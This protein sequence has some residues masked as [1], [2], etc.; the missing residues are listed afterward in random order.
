MEITSSSS[1][2]IVTNSHN[3][4]ENVNFFV[5]YTTGGQSKKSRGF[6]F[7]WFHGQFVMV[8]STKDHQW[9]LE[10]PKDKI[11]HGEWTQIA[12][13][14]N[15]K[16]DK[17]TAFQNGNK[18]AQT[19]SSAADRPDVNF[20]IMTI[21]RPNNAVNAQFMMKMCMADLALWDKALGAKEIEKTFKLSKSL[22]VTPTQFR[23][24]IFAYSIP[25]CTLSLCRLKRN[26]N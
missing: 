11:K 12:F 4:K 18:I 21:G 26:R 20:T 17:L 1:V 22:E 6:A 15:G 5:N 24:K 7:L 23:M 16:T 19:D 8:V 10:I 13:V 14:W 25:S 2:K 9:K 3:Y